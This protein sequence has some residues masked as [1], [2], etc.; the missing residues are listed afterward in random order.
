MGRR[1]GPCLPWA[2]PIALARGVPLVVSGSPTPVSVSA[3]ATGRAPV[4][5]RVRP[6]GPAARAGVRAGDYL[7]AVNGLRP[8]DAIDLADLAAEGRAALTL[9]RGE[10]RVEL[11]VVAAPGEHLGLEF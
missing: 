8:R 7:L 5:A 9:A 6:G 2:R 11:N 3:G 4:I 10:Q 1:P